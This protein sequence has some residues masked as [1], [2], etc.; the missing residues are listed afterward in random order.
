MHKIADELIALDWETINIKKGMVK[1]SKALIIPCLFLLGGIIFIKSTID[2]LNKAGASLT[3]GISAEI[4]MGC[5]CIFASIS[6]CK[7]LL[8]GI[9]DAFYGPARTDKAT[10][11]REKHTQTSESKDESN[12]QR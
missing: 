1:V 8:S 3:P 10:E 9:S 2:Q 4:A 6:M 12:E 5:G 11:P 7:L